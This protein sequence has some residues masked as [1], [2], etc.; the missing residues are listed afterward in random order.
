M[1]RSDFESPTLQPMTPEPALSAP[2]VDQKVRGG[3]LGIVVFAI[4]LVASL[5][6]NVRLCAGGVGQF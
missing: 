5:A 6:L 4:I 3:R 1:D 2:G